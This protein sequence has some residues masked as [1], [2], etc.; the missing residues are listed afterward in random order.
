MFI[1]VREMVDRRLSTDHRYFKVIGSDA[2]TYLIRRET[3]AWQWEL[4][5]DQFAE[6]IFLGTCESGES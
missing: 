3:L 5:F 1:E 6:R 4:V 2:A